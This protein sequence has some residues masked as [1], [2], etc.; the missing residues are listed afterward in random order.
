MV[1]RSSIERRKRG[2]RL[3]PVHVEDRVAHRSADDLELVVSLGEID[4]HLG[5][6]DG[7]SGRRK[8]GR[9]FKQ[10]ADRLV[11]RVLERNQGKAVLRNFELGAGVAHLQ[12]QVRGLRHRQTMVAGDH[13]HA[14]L[15]E[16]LLQLGRPDRLFANDPCQLQNFDRSGA[17]IELQQKPGRTS[18]SDEVR[19]DWIGGV[20]YGNA[21][22]SGDAAPNDS[23][24]RLGCR[25]KPRASK[26]QQLSRTVAPGK[27]DARAAPI[28]EISPALDQARLRR[29]MRLEPGGRLAA[30]ATAGSPASQADAADRLTRSACGRRA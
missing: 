14:R 12:A 15:G 10:V 24:P 8:R 23:C 17:P 19:G 26:P 2:Q 21:R 11:A 16:D 29:R 20:A 28:A 22:R 6:R 18:P 30:H 3:D 1:A 27:P 25:I 4:R 9:A 5:G 13:N 7:V